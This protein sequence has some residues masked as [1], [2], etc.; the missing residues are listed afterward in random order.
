MEAETVL[1]GLKVKKTTD[2]LVG[3]EEEYGSGRSWGVIMI[4]MS[5]TCDSFAKQTYDRKK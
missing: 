5:F 4:K 1:M 2:S 3:R